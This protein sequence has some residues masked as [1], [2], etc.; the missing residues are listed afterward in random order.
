MTEYRV[1]H[2]QEIEAE[3]DVEAVLEAVGLIAM[4]GAPA[5]TVVRLG[6]NNTRLVTVDFDGLLEAVAMEVRVPGGHHVAEYIQDA[7]GAYLLLDYTYEVHGVPDDT[8][9][10]GYITLA[11]T[12]DWFDDEEEAEAANV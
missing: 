5:P 6:E 4:G 1:T 11:V 9:T 3:S 10:N 7:N 12:G 2:T 8:D